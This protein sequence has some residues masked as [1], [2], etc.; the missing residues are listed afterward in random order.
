MV[1][2]D[3]LKLELAKSPFRSRFTLKDKDL[4]YIA[5]KGFARIALQ[6]E[7]II[8]TR[9]APANPTNDG[10]QTPMTGHVVFIAQHAT[11]SCCRGCL[12]KWQK[13][14]KSRALTDE[15]I[16]SI[17]ANIIAFLKEKAGNIEEIP[18]TPDLF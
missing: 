13:I 17:V 14:P 8:K 4:M 3:V 7:E 10:S 15:E 5:E 12:A 1:K 16:S 2:Y 11:G 6:A 9:L 18:H